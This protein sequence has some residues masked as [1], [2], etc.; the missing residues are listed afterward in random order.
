MKRKLGTILLASVGIV[1]AI[2]GSA[3]AAGYSTTAYLSHGE[4]EDRGPQMSIQEEISVKGVN[5]GDQPLKAMGRYASF[6]FDTAHGVI[7]VY[8]G[9]TRYGY[10]NVD[11]HSYYPE[12]SILDSNRPAWSYTS[13]TATITNR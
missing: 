4:T 5:T 9:E 1:S 12:A 2:A 11:L 6:F 7:T 8:P 10:E 13:G 3:G